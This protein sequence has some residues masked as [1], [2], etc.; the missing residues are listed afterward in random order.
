[1][2]SAPSVRCAYGKCM[3]NVHATCLLTL[4]N[5]VF[6]PNIFGPM[7]ITQRTTMYVSEY[8][9][10]SIRMLLLYCIV[11]IKELYIISIF[12][13]NDTRHSH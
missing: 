9:V 6:C 2:S 7:G 12:P 1:M 3:C 13:S 8:T 4:I 11:I 5:F 10:L